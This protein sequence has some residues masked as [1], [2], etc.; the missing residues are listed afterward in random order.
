MNDKLLHS[1]ACAFITCFTFASS[2]SVFKFCSTVPIRRQD[3]DDDDD[4]DINEGVD[5]AV[6]RGHDD[7]GDVEEQ[8]RC[9]DNDVG[10]VEIESSPA[11]ISHDTQVLGEEAVVRKEDTGIRKQLHP[12]NIL[13]LAVISG[14]VAMGVGI[15]KEI[16]DACELLWTGGTSSWGDVL[17]DF[18]GVVVGETVIFVLVV[19]RYHCTASE[20][21]GILS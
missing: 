17:A 16:L 21:K 15:A 18:L 13:L 20:G 1:L 2:L 6:R 11:M 7:D 14:I 4:D 5:C 10:N 12:K 3:D 9:R 19:L 8:E